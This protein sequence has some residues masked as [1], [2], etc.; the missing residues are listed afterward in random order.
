MINLEQQKFNLQA[1]TTTQL[2]YNTQKTA[3]QGLKQI[4]AGMNIDEV[5]DIRDEMEEVRANQ[6]ELNALISEPAGDMLDDDELMDE[7]NELDEEEAMSSFAQVPA[8]P[9]GPTAAPQQAMPAIP[10]APT[11]ALATPAAA[12][13]LAELEALMA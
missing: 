12:D 7:L 5:E 2:V 3:H 10:A 6:E 4:Q 1:A 11:G 9:V 13:E 8:L